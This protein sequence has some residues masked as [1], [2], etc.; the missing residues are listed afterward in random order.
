MS[1]IVEVEVLLALC[2]EYGMLVV[3]IRGNENENEVQ[4]VLILVTMNYK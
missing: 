3:T 2:I 1:I 4:I